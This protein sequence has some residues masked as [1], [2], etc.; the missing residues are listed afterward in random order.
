MDLGLLVRERPLETAAS[1][2]V[3][4]T[5]HLG[6][7]AYVEDGS[8]DLQGQSLAYEHISDEAWER[9]LQ[10]R[11]G[12]RKERMNRFLEES[13]KAGNSYKDLRKVGVSEVVLDGFFE[14]KGKVA[15]LE[16]KADKVEVRIGDVA[17]EVGTTLKRIGK[18]MTKVFYYA[19]C[20]YPGTLLAIP[21]IIRKGYESG[22]GYDHAEGELADDTYSATSFCISGCI[23]SVVSTALLMNHWSIYGAGAVCMIAGS[24]ALFGTYELIRHG[25]R[26]A[27][28]KRKKY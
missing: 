27:R 9:I 6:D 11:R 7:Q 23:V 24:N 17:R 21:T 18:G 1:D 28:E 8:G 20:V 10:R 12:E 3:D 5:E 19:P 2:D 16:Q 14:D 22:T 15:G 26:K 25:V 13:V 4:K